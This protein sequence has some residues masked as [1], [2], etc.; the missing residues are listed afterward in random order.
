MTIELK[1]APQVVIMLLVLGIFL[2]IGAVTFGQIQTSQ[3]TNRAIINNTPVE[4][5]NFTSADTDF[6]L[7][8]NSANETFFRRILNNTVIVSN[9]TNIFLN[10]VKNGNWTVNTNTGTIQLHATGVL[11]VNCTGDEGCLYNI[12]YTWVEGNTAIDSLTLS[13]GAITNISNFQG[14]L[15][16]VLAASILIG[17]VFAVLLLGGKIGDSGD[18][19]RGGL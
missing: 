16:T 1:D 11:S 15:G 8:H 3:E 9:A 19:R 10:G 18:K 2:F 12:S 14:T 4:Q 6:N 7:A 5:I 17:I 13:Q